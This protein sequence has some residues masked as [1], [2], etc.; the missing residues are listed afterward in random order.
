MRTYQTLAAI[1]WW[2]CCDRH[3]R[4][5]SLIVCFCERLFFDTVLPQRPLTA[6]YIF[7][8]ASVTGPDPPPALLSI[9]AV[10]QSG[11]GL[12][13]QMCQLTLSNEDLTAAITH[14]SNPTSYI[15]QSSRS[16]QR[17]PF[18]GQVVQVVRTPPHRLH[19]PIIPSSAC[20]NLLQYNVIS[21]P[22][23]HPAL[24]QPCQSISTGPNPRWLQSKGRVRSTL[25]N[26]GIR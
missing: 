25:K 12:L 17:S 11:F 6:Q 14:H 13:P 9:C 8:N 22:F 15:S 1:I 18:K 24:K 19:L 16:I 23:S 3:H 2:R 4:R 5:S 7:C 20:H 21:I 26:G 10:N